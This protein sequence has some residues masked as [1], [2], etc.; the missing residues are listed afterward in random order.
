MLWYDRE[1]EKERVRRAGRETTRL[2]TCGC[3]TLQ[4]ALLH[5]MNALLL[6]VA[7]C[8]HVMM[9]HTSPACAIFIQQHGLLCV[10]SYVLAKQLRPL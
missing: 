3:N 6:L 1:E 10:I 8:L 4:A 7:L 5:E 9:H 2:F